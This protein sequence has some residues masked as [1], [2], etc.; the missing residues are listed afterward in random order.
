MKKLLTTAVCCVSLLGLAAC[1]GTIDFEESYESSIDE[2]V[3]GI[4]N[5]QLF[6]KLTE[7]YTELELDT[8]SIHEYEDKFGNITYYANPV[9]NVVIEFFEV[10]KIDE[11]KYESTIGSL[12]QLTILYEKEGDAQQYISKLMGGINQ[13]IVQDLMKDE[14]LEQ[15]EGFND[16]WI[17]YYRLPQEDIEGVWMDEDEYNKTLVEFLEKSGID[18]SQPIYQIYID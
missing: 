15:A 10:E 11:P 16:L 6:A 17:E 18:G 1:S 9:E 12:Y 4:T 7:I 3:I 14:V 8:M 2:Q 13:I 5:E